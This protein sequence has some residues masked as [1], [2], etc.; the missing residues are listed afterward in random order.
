M[1]GYSTSIGKSTRHITITSRLFLSPLATSLS[2]S[3][4]S[5]CAPTPRST[6]SS[7]TPTAKGSAW[8]GWSRWAASP[9][10]PKTARPP[11]PEWIRTC[12]PRTR[13]RAR[14]ARG[15]RGSS[16]SPR[17][18]TSRTSF[19]R[20]SPFRDTVQSG[21]SYL[22]QGFEDIVL[23][24][25]PDWYCNYLLPRQALTTQVEKHNKILRQMGRPAL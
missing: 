19:A 11:P 6:S 25:S 20:W 1:N 3:P 4:T 14:A 9:A 22:P 23:G 8:P 16:S 15:P 12:C 13:S 24:S 7:T 17:G 5:S 2:A 21:A 18:R 10:P